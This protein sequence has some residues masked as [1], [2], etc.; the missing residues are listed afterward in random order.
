MENIEELIVKLTQ[1]TEKVRPAP[2]PFRLSLKWMGWALVYLLLSFALTGLR[3][4]IMLKLHEP[5]FAAEIAALVAIFI[6]T[7]VSAALLS[8][9]D[10]HQM[11]RL[12]FAPVISFSLFSL[13]LLFAWRADT[14]PAPLPAHSFE[15]TLAI[16]LYSLVPAIWTFYSM[17]KFATTHFHWAGSI[18]LLSAFSIGALWLRLHEIND[19]IRHVVEWHYLPMIACGMI[20]WGLERKY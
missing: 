17:R 18:A 7:S 20:G 4:D 2:H 13:I 9:P 15:C 14:P 10:M 19:S 1:D 6:S 3:P 12:A 8:F 11:R 5:W 16:T